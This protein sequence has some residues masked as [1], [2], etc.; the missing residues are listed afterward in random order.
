[1]TTF[2]E[3]TC[4]ATCRGQTTHLTV[5]VS[6]GNNPVDAGVVAD[7]SVL[8]IDEDDFKVFE[9]GILVDPVT[10]E[11]TEIATD[12][13]NA[14]LCDGTKVATH[15]E[16]VDTLVLGFT[17]NNTL[18]VW[19]LTAT[20]ADGNTVHDV[21]LLGFVSKTACLVWTRWVRELGDF[22]TLAVGGGLVLIVFCLMSRSNREQW[23]VW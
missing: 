8:R 18:V 13:A 11:D 3:T 10:V 7:N 14:L 16:L 15:L 23:K 5:L 19:A 21:T 20:T 2:A 22:G 6:W 1:M 4:G 9:G 17:V 12:T